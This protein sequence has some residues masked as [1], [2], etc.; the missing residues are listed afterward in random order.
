MV[1]CLH[2]IS[3]IGIEIFGSPVYVDT[4][5]SENLNTDVASGAGGIMRGGSCA[6]TDCEINNKKY[7]VRI[8]F[9]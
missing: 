4:G 5:T 3:W 8:A 2:L 1:S 6:K 7:T 9:I